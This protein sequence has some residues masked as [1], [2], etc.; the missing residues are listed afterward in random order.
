MVEKTAKIAFRFELENQSK[1]RPQIVKNLSKFAIKSYRNVVP[2]QRKQNSTENPWNH[3]NLTKNNRFG[4]PKRGPIWGKFRYNFVTFGV[5]EPLWM[6]SGQEKR[7][8][9]LSMS[10]FGRFWVDF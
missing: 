3:S 7:W 2:L 1:T 8:R 9:T 4:G 6:R 5:F 10:I